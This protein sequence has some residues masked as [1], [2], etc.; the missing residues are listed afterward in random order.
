[1]SRGGG[2][3]PNAPDSRSGPEWVRRFKSGPRH[4]HGKIHVQILLRN[5]MSNSP[6]PNSQYLNLQTTRNSHSYCYQ[7]YRGDEKGKWKTLLSGVR[8]NMG[9]GGVTSSQTVRKLTE[10][11]PFQTSCE[12]RLLGYPGQRTAGV[13]QDQHSLL[14]SCSLL[15]SLAFFPFQSTARFPFRAPFH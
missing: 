14:F 5:A 10:V 7:I 3:W 6:S 1:M 12:Q 2:A 13:Y 15:S 11:S 8:E 9:S 4:Y